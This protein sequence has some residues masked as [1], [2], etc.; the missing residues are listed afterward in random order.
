MS[1][2]ERLKTVANINQDILNELKTTKLKKTLA[3]F[4][5]YGYTHTENILLSIGHIYFSN[6][7]LQS[8]I[9]QIEDIKTMPHN[10]VRHR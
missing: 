10:Y 2:Q 1:E 8:G 7:S 6:P 4:G 5:K 9:I 3:Y